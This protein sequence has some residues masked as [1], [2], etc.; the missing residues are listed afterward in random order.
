MSKLILQ[1]ALLSMLTTSNGISAANY[2]FIKNNY[3]QDFQLQKFLKDAILL[4]D[5]DGSSLQGDD[6]TYA[7]G[8]DVI[9]SYIKSID[10]KA[11][12]GLVNEKDEQKKLK[13]DSNLFIVNI[14]VGQEVKKA[15][16]R[17]INVNLS[18]EQQV[19]KLINSFSNTIIGSN[20][21]I[22]IKYE[23]IINFLNVLVKKTTNK[24][25]ITLTNDNDEDKNLVIGENKI[26][27]TFNVNGKNFN[28]ILKI[29]DVKEDNS[30]IFTKILS[31][32]KA[33]VISTIDGSNSVRILDLIESEILKYV[34]LASFKIAKIEKIS[35]S[36]NKV[37]VKITIANE[38][39]TKNFKII[40][41]N[42]NLLAAE[43]TP[44]QDKL[45]K[46]K[47]KLNGV[48]FSSNGQLTTRNV[49]EDTLPIILK[50]LSSYK[51]VTFSISDTMDLKKNLVEK[52]NKIVLKMALNDAI[53]TVDV[54]ISEVIELDE[55]RLER[56]KNSIGPF[57]GSKLT[58]ASNK[59]DLLKLIEKT[60]KKIDKKIKVEL[61][62]SEDEFK[63]I[64]G[65]N[66]I[67]ILLK[68]GEKS[69]AIEINLTNVKKSDIDKLNEIVDKFFVD[70][71]DGKQLQANTEFKNSLS[72]IQEYVDKF[73]YKVKTKIINENQMLRER[74]NEIEVELSLGKEKIKTK[75]RIINVQKSKKDKL[76]DILAKIQPFDGSNF[77]TDQKF[78]DTLEFVKEEISKILKTNGL[79]FNEIDVTSTSGEQKLISGIDNYFNINLVVDGQEVTT[80]INIINIK[81]SDQDRIDAISEQMK[82]KEIDGSHLTTSDTVENALKL[83][84]DEIKNLDNTVTVELDEETDAAK[85]L[86][87]GDNEV[88]IKISSGEKSRVEKIKIV[89]VKMS[90]QDKFEQFK[91]KINNFTFNDHGFTTE[92]KKSFALEEIMNKLCD[93]EDERNE[94]TW[95]WLNPEDGNSNLKFGDNEFKFKVT[96]NGITEEAT[97]NIN[98]VILSK[99]DLFNKIKTEISNLEI[100]GSDFESGQVLN[101]ALEKI[102]T[103]ID[104]IA[105]DVSI[106]I[107]DDHILNDGEN[108]VRIM[109]K[110]D[111]FESVIL[112]IK[113][114]N[115]KLSD[116]DRVTKFIDKI[117]DKKIDG[118]NLTTD[119]KIQEMLENIR[120]L[121]KEID[122]NIT[123][124]LVD[125]DIKNDDLNSNDNHIKLNISSGDYTEEVIVTVTDVK[126][127]D[128]DRIDNVIKT[129][130]K[131]TI[132]GSSLTTENT[133]EDLLKLILPLIK[134]IDPNVEINIADEDDLELTLEEGTNKIIVNIKSG[135]LI[136]RQE[137]SIT[138]VQK[139]EKDFLEEISNKLANYE[140]D[141]S[142]FTTDNTYGD[143]LNYLKDWVKNSDEYRNIKID[144]I[145]GENW[146]E[147]LKENE[148]II[149]FNI[150]I[151]KDN[152]E[153]KIKVINV[154]L[155]DS[156]I[157]NK[158]DTKFNNKECDLSN[159]ETDNTYEDALNEIRSEILKEFPNAKVVL[160]DNSDK[161]LVEN[162]NEIKINVEINGI[163]KDIVVRGINVK[164]SNNDRIDNLISKINEKQDIDGSSL[165]TN[166]N[167]TDGLNLIRQ[168]IGELDPEAIINLENSKFAIKKLNENDNSISITI[169]LNGLT[170]TIS[171]NVNNVKLC[172]YDV[173]NNIIKKLSNDQID[174]SQL[175]TDNTYNDAL[176]LVKSKIAELYKEEFTVEF[177]NDII[178]TEKLLED[179]N[180]I[181]INVKIKEE[182]RL[183]KLKVVNVKISTAARIQNIIKILKENNQNINSKFQSDQQ[184]S[185]LLQELQEQV[186]KI[187]PEATIK[188]NEDLLNH[189]LRDIKMVNVTI[190]VNDKEEGFNYSISS[191]KLSNK[192]LFDEIERMSKDF[193][194][195]NLTTDNVQQDILV[196]FRQTLTNLIKNG[197][198][199][200]SELFDSEN[201]ANKNLKFD[202]DKVLVKI[203]LKDGTNKVIT[204][205]LDNIKKASDLEKLE[206]II[207]FLE[208]T[209]PIR[210][211]T[212]CIREKNYIT[213]AIV[214]QL[215][216][217]DVIKNKDEVRI[218]DIDSIGTIKK[219]S[220]LIVG[221]TYTV[222]V[223]VKVGNYEKEMAIKFTVTLLSDGICILD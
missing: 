171:V 89:N 33:K 207:S 39:I 42:N 56:V 140:V 81:L 123:I 172:D 119:V 129:L 188:I 8:L 115:V 18:A 12:V 125:E 80:K 152:K 215:I 200:D 51:D 6:L 180:D 134:E 52:D 15:V 90:N 151:L 116:R 23:N 219:L 211:P 102:Q 59:A 16:T 138:N 111:D 202:K 83:I 173:M 154:K 176:E 100:D 184:I 153:V 87:M 99:N 190:K 70:S 187:D 22:K 60:I 175:T 69:E 167:L 169:I 109:V 25:K 145:N 40:N 162:E 156:D 91:L 93:S 168:Y 104:K 24:I 181:V 35:N 158:I 75:V 1:L 36:I 101:D 210:I 41:F 74:N 124:S 198:S 26:K 47:T 28:K 105:K 63:L 122:P 19:D 107:V 58:T 193:K 94:V 132:D 21:D 203:I 79:K 30:V 96:K 206:K 77:T 137:F 194:V 130:E 32:F 38:E 78:N 170:R 114:V 44:D 37:K 84:S 98:N 97:I 213:R 29:K 174:G 4:P 197:Y 65:T 209:K 85:K 66:S 133:N 127:S 17:L 46:I 160:T 205:E 57:D 161:K 147:K 71:L 149:D 64:E 113:I 216:K 157:L 11:T 106:K 72:L 192:D 136:K 110:Y 31:D 117:K 27:I 54:T 88:S 183:I 178:A 196:A 142:K 7:D 5:I 34:P 82:V 76:N 221:R 204:L 120:E 3:D 217:S 179:V 103:E 195:F 131:T 14:I 199:I 43:P 159:L 212:L 67:K 112:P 92:H 222:K 9:E 185:E 150:S 68:I 139:S 146:K 45:N 218:E 13:N 49:I 163:K 182:E 55:D 144:L 164:L 128:S 223:K 86:I 165:T 189:N 177:E 220:G 155:S 214:D 20:L 10:S 61:E 73:N 62:E 186:K 143:L 135:N 201:S 50:A 95:E 141:G 208:K 53:D 118:S 108:R 48:F 166:H 121:Y 148:N 191:V 2:L 126:L